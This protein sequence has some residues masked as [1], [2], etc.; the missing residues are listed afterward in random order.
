M[1]KLVNPR[2]AACNQ[3]ERSKMKIKSYL[4]GLAFSAA[5]CTA[6][7]AAAAV[8]V[9][10]PSSGSFQDDNVEY[11]LDAQ[12]NIKTTGA[13][14][15]GDVLV[16]YVTWPEIRLPDSTLFANLGPGGLQVTGISMIQVD[17]IAGGTFTFKPYAAFEATYG[18]GAMAALFSHAVGT[19]DI[20]CANVSVATCDGQAVIPGGLASVW[21]VA[22]FGAT[23]DF[24]RAT[25]LLGGGAGFNIDTV[26]SLDQSTK[27]AGSNYA[28]SVLENNTGYVF[29]L[30]NCPLCNIFGVGSDGKAQI[31]GSGDVLG[32]LGLASPFFARSDF[33]FSFTVSRVPE[34]GSLALFGL[35]LA[36]L[37]FT[38][39]RRQA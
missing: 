10:L 6:T 23:D 28:L 35:A 37:G 3:K 32:G 26:A 24:W 18:A 22:G 13:L 8:F 1:L 16:A 27:V 20:S 30:L 14:V 21:A 11:V 25:D 4:K 19:F 9:P 17:T 5:V 15:E 39:R 12:G 36:G 7:T 31:V 34:P 33:D 38:G 29:D 2:I